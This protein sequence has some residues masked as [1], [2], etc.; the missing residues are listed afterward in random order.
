MWKRVFCTSETERKVLYLEEA[1][2]S[3]EVRRNWNVQNLGLY[4]EC[5]GVPVRDWLGI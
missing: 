3:E 5:N 1:N 4:R 2:N